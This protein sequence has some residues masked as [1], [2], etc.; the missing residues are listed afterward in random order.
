MFKPLQA[1]VLLAA[2]AA[3]SLPAPP[4]QAARIVVDAR[5][6]RRAVIVRPGWP[7]R[8]PLPFVV[9][10]PVRAAYRVDARIFLPPV[11]WAPVVVTRPAPAAVVWEDGEAFARA[12][13]WTE[14]TLNADTRGSR[15]LLSVEQG[16]VQFDF[17]E[18]VFDN[19]ETRVVDFN[20]ATQHE[21]TYP[22]LDFRDGRKVDHVR[23]VARSMSQRAHVALLM[24]R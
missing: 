20:R 18:V 24:E 5:L 17:A 22:L 16:R 19:G 11:I 9:V 10:H 2:L 4:A 12:E 13:D 21:G 23:I 7:I 8:R 15:L 14:F 6:G 1:I 3:A